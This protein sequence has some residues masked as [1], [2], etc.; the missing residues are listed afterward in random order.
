MD[1]P[2]DLSTSDRFREQNALI[3]RRASI[4]SSVSV[5]IRPLE[6]GWVCVSLSSELKLSSS[7]SYWKTEFPAT[8][9]FFRE[10]SCCC[11]RR[12]VAFVEELIVY[13]EPTTECC[14]SCPSRSWIRFSMACIWGSSWSRRLMI[15]S[16]GS[17]SSD[18]VTE[19]DIQL[20][21][22]KSK[23]DHE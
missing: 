19:I 9:I 20:R 17:R 23:A 8:T 7:V 21:R 13:P 5:R 16:D 22:T 3:S 14:V 15:I 10:A 18:F 1:S 12:F 11:L 4:S 2:L 6:S